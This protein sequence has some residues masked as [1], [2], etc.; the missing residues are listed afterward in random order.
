MIHLKVKTNPEFDNVEVK[1]KQNLAFQIGFRKFNSSGIFS[2]FITV[3]IKII[4]YR[5]VKRPN[6]VRN[7]KTKGI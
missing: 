4:T 2:Q 5:K 7:Y 3:N 6:T 1:S